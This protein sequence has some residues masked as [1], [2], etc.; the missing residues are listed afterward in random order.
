M[1][2]VKREESSILGKDLPVCQ[3]GLSV[4]PQTSLSSSNSNSSGTVQ[5]LFEVGL[6]WL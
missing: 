5:D 3:T 4:L 2:T 6:L 1:L